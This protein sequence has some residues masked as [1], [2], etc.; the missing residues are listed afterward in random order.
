M[1]RAENVMAKDGAT[2]SR[3][4]NIARDKYI[5]CPDKP[6]KPPEPSV[7]FSLIRIIQ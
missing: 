1:L 5:C 7:L 3:I 4:D 6:Q 2:W